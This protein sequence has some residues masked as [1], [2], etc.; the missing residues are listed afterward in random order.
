MKATLLE[1]SKLLEVDLATPDEKARADKLREAALSWFRENGRTF[2]WRSTR[3]PYRILVAEICLQKTNADKVVPIFEKI[4]EKYPTVAALA[5]ANLNDLSDHFARLGLFKRGSFLLEIARA[6]VEQHG[7]VVPRDRGTLLKV[8]GIGDY[9]AN[10]VLCLAY[11]DRLPLL[12]GSTQRVLARV[13][14]RCADKPAWANRAM[15]DF[16][17]AILPDSQAREFN[18]ALIDI[19]DKCCRPR[20]PKCAT[21]PLETICLTA[22]STRRSPDGL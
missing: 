9:T 17:Q 8:R 10:S 19:A 21:C 18:L 6:I 14:D 11:G 3:D 22:K 15:R 13:F 7:G 16:M 4:V 2:P 12:D 20:K 1:Q 5:K